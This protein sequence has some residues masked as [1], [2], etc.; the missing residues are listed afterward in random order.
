[1]SIKIHS[2]SLKAL[3]KYFSEKLD[4]LYPIEEIDALF[5]LG[6]QHYLS[7]SK[8]DYMMDAER[9]VSESDILR[10]RHLSRELKREVPIQYILGEC[11]F[12][13]LRILVNEDVLIPRPETEE[14]LD[15]IFKK[16]GSIKNAVDL[17]SGSGCI[18]LAL[19][20]NYPNAEVIGIE[21]SKK[22]LALSKENAS[23]NSIDV[24]FLKAD[25]LNEELTLPQLDLIVSNPPYV[26]ESEKAL[27][28]KNV[29]DHE[30]EMALFVDDA[31]PLIFYRAIVKIAVEK[32]SEEGWLFMEINEKFGKEIMLMLEQAGLHKKLAINKDLNGKDRWVCAKK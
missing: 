5:F 25:V 20:K 14:I 13:D 6:L 24:N 32:L 7:L 27:M 8:L 17:C 3:R 26:L 30:P 29:L 4:D 22:A 11:S 31:D 15:D 12:M 16:I 23:K 2:N 21:L 10:F 19:K 18:A 1:M 9:S 28:K